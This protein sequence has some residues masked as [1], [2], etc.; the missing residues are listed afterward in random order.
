MPFVDHPENPLL[1]A[2]W[3]NWLVG[4]PSVLLPEEAPDG[5]WHLFANN[6]T[7]I[8]ACTSDDGV[9]WR[10]RCRVDW[11][12]NRPWVIRADGRYHLYYQRFH[13]LFQRSRL[14][15]RT[16]PDLRGWSAPAT[17]LEPTLPW[18]GQHVSNACVLP[19][20][21]R[22]W[23]Y[24]S[25]NLVHLDDMGFSEPAFISVAYSDRPDGPFER[26]GE[27]LFGPDPTH[28]FRAAGAGA[29][30]VY[31]HLIPGWL[32]G[33][34]NGIYRDPTGRAGSAVLLLR[35][36]DGLR[37]EEHPSNPILAPSGGEPAWR[38][39]HVYQLD[40]KRVGDDLWVWYN[41][42]SGWRFGVERI[43]LAVRRGT[44]DLWEGELGEGPA[45]TGAGGS[46]HV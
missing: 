33:F 13:A 41:A 42:R 5:R 31:D 12:G 16:S 44:G 28:R 35:S 11:N 32:A 19:R 14:V 18:E 39:A 2:R 38:R 43:G 23:L 1:T 45:R 29:I 6:V 20:D 15:V 24:Y 21:G 9:H 37:W 3:W 40:V 36:T 46:G 4:D 22:W 27:P 7:G 25:A 30:K 34:Q 8:Y 17:V 26:H 10:Y